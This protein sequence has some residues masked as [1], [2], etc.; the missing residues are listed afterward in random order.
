M[1]CNAR[2]PFLVIISL[3]LAVANAQWEIGEPAKDYQGLTV[4]F[5]YKVQSAR[6]PEEVVIKYYK[7]EGCEV[8][9]TWTGSPNNKP[10]FNADVYNGGSN[11][12]GT[13]TVS[14]IN[15]CKFSVVEITPSHSFWFV[16]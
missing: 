15:I 8:P 10:F 6:K 7:D 4:K 3:L 16:R 13:K 11:G 9:V 14:T 1:M 12:D 5:D 2:G